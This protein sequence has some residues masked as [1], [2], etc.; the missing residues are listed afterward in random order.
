MGVRRKILV[1]LLFCIFIG[2]AH[3]HYTLN[4]EYYQFRVDVYGRYV[5]WN[6]ADVPILVNIN[7]EFT[8]VETDII[9]QAVHSW[10]EEVGFDLFRLAESPEDRFIRTH[11]IF[12]QKVD[13]IP[14]RNGLTILGLCYSY[15][16][17]AGIAPRVR[18]SITNVR[19]E[20]IENKDQTEFLRTIRHELGHAIG[21]GHDH[22]RDSL[23]Y[24][25]MDHT[26]GALEER[27]R[28]VVRMIYGL[29]LSSLASP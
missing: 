22:N 26:E 3:S 15:F 19:I 8:P 24:P 12:I 23:M 10:N 11:S 27:D 9:V 4:T 7:S 6:L 29:D 1:F 20:V 25:R 2:C 17:Y 18:H 16:S 14:R 5:H 21:L 28:A 13:S